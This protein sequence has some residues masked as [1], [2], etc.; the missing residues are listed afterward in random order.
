[1]IVIYCLFLGALIICPFDLV[2]PW[3]YRRFRHIHARLE[4]PKQFIYLSKAPFI[5]ALSYLFNFLKGYGIPYFINSWFYND[6][7]TFAS[8]VLTL[9]LHTRSP[10]DGFKNRRSGIWVLWGIYFYLLPDYFWLFPVLFFG[11]TLL[12]NSPY[13]GVVLSTVMFI[14]VFWFNQTNPLDLFIN[15]GIFM[16]VFLAVLDPLMSHLERK[17]GTIEALFDSRGL[18]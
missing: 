16:V 5:Y 4:R 9:A 6:F 2:L 17:D 14:F 7:L 1:M 3:L 10:L 15:F 18:H 11:L 8:V 12:F 13:I